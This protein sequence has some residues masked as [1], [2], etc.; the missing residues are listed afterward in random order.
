MASAFT[1]AY[2]A[3][4]LG[5][6][7]PDF[8]FLDLIGLNGFFFAISLFPCSLCSTTEVGFT[9]RTLTSGCTHLLPATCFDTTL[10]GCYVGI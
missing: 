1:R 3:L 5:V 6:A 8:F 7:L 2:N 9:R 10:F 4:F